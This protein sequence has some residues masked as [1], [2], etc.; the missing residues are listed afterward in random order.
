M[1]FSPN[2][3]VFIIIQTWNR[4]RTV[5]SQHER[6]CRT[7][8]ADPAPGLARAR[9]A[10]DP[11]RGPQASYLKPLAGDRFVGWS[12]VQAVGKELSGSSRAGPLRSGPRNS[13]PALNEQASLRMR[14]CVWCSSHL[15]RAK[16]IPQ[17]PSNGEQLH[18]S[19]A[20]TPDLPKQKWKVT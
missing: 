4:R 18:R 6:L 12:S 20:M 8:K 17:C 9:S 3:Y 19:P 15:C 7:F 2:E 14:H 11:T 5:G 10:P 13:L 16:F 1:R